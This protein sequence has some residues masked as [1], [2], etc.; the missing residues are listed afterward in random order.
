M[1]RREH[2]AGSIYADQE[3]GFPQATTSEVSSRRSIDHGKPSYLNA[4]RLSDKRKLQLN[5][6]GYHLDYTATRMHPMRHAALR[7][8][9]TGGQQRERQEITL[10]LVQ[11]PLAN[12][13]F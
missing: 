4:N 10:C 8:L 5:H 11:L 1:R 6:Q 2:S 7:P 3:V 12:N 13:M 9:H